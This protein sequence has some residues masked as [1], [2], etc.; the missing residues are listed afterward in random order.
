M[1]P[2]LITFLIT[3][4]LYTVQG[5]N[6]TGVVKN[7]T[8]LIDNVLLYYKI[9]SFSSITNK[10]GVF[11]INKSKDKNDTLIISKIGYTSIKIP[12]NHLVS[13]QEIEMGYK[14]ENLS[15]VVIKPLT[16]KA[17]LDS[18]ILNFNKKNDFCHLYEGVYIEGTLNNAVLNKFLFA[19]INLDIKKESKNTMYIDN[20]KSFQVNYLDQNKPAFF[21]ILN[22]VIQ[23]LDFLPLVQK[24]ANNL[25]KYY[26]L[27]SKSVFDGKNI[28]ILEFKDS[29]ESKFY[30]KLTVSSDD[31]SILKYENKLPLSLKKQ[32]FIPESNSYIQ[33]IESNLELNFRP[34][35]DKYA[36]YSIEGKIIGDFFQEKERTPL[37]SYYKYI[38]NNI[39]ENNCI[40]KKLISTKKAIFKLISSKNSYTLNKLFNTDE[41]NFLKKNNQ[42][43]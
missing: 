13:Y 7:N 3:L 29:K 26:I 30:S 8:V 33:P 36:I 38:V 17:I 1:K 31:F 23:G 5:Q 25:N 14:I 35:K 20:D 11:E 22:E 42:F 19:G 16:I 43:N 9:S 24:M 10:N 40:K 4:F 21:P 39:C 28:L 34:Y 32:Q 27:K 12:S 6:L 2:K 37:I 15:E 18:V 41:I